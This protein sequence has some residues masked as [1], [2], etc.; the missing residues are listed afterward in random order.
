M[1]LEANHLELLVEVLDANC[2]RVRVVKDDRRAHK[3]EQR[4]GLWKW[5][6]VVVVEDL[7]PRTRLCLDRARHQ[8]R[9]ASTSANPIDR[10]FHRPLFAAELNEYA[11]IGEVEE[12]RV[13]PD[14]DSRAVCGIRQ[15]LS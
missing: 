13:A 11:V 7:L 4:S 15:H 8:N 14:R 10:Y 3:V 6:I 5:L 1:I 2:E 9:R 12:V